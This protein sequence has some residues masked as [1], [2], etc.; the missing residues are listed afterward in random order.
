MLLRFQEAQYPI[1]HFEMRWWEVNLFLTITGQNMI[2]IF[3]VDVRFDT[4]LSID[5]YPGYTYKNMRKTYFL[6]LEPIE[7]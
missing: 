5:I 4:K 2:Q 7:N 3:H 1:Y 6:C